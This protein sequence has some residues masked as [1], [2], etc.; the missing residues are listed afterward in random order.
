MVDGKQKHLE[1][2]KRNSFD[3]IVLSSSGEMDLQ[4][5]LSRHL[6]EAPI[7]GDEILGNLGLFLTSKNLSRL[8][9][10]SEIY[11]KI[12]NMHGVVME[13]GVRWGQTLSF[14][15]ALRGIF[16]PFNRHRKIIGF[17]TFEGFKGVSDKDG[18]K[19]RCGEGS[20]AVPGDY[21]QFLDAVLGLQE[22]LNPMAHIKRYELVKGDAAHTVTDYLKSHP[23]T[24]IA[25]AIFDFDIYTPTKAALEA[26]K[27]HLCKGSLLV[28][29]ELCDDIFPGETIA[30]NEVFGLNNLKIQRLPITARLSY[31]VM[32]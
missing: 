16:E 20:Y 2:M 14:L 8:L 10:F 17:D 6:R 11:Q 25:L 29:D 30:L 4:G 31:V 26:V 21:E 1:E 19:C 22:G 18:G 23:E 15:L 24:I 9:F 27:P 28:F 32:E 13:F 7:P 12:I 5:R 3:A